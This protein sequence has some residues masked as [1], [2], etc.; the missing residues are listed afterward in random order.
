MKFVCFLLIICCAKGLRA[1]ISNK[2]FPPSFKFGAST[3][4]YQIEGG[5]DADGKGPSVWDTFV[6]KGGVT[7]DNSTG[8]VACDSYHKWEE[9]VQILKELGAQI[10]R[11][12][13]SWPR[14]LPDGTTKNIN[15]KGVEYYLNLI[16]ALKANNIEPIITLYHWD[17]PQSLEE[18]GGW[19]NPVTADYFGEYTRLCFQLFGSY[20]KYWITLN[21]PFIQCL[22]GY[23]VGLLAPGVVNLGEG[24]YK[25]AH[26]QLLA[27]AQ[28]YHIY[29]DEFRDSQNGKVGVNIPYSWM[30]PK[31]PNNSL[32]VEATERYFQFQC[33]LFANPVLIGNWPQLVIDRV[34]NLS[35]QEG[36][37]TSRLPEL[38]KEEIEFI[39]GTSDYIAL[40]SYSAS[41]VSYANDSTPLIPSYLTDYNVETSMN[42]SWPTSTAEWLVSYPEGL[43]LALN[44]INDR[45]HPSEIIITENGWSDDGQLNDIGRQE[46]MEGYLNSIL[47]AITEDGVNVTGYSTW[48]LLD[49]FEWAYG[50]TQS[51]GIIKVDFKDPNRTR[52]WKDSATWYKNVIENRF[53]TK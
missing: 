24:I 10:Y 44:Q 19:L 1:N 17:L 23:T 26:V 36:L 35:A 3:A 11:F 45:Y 2:V 51:Y 30:G 7:V 50:Y 41:L 15:Q 39:N 28:A 12:S 40:N 46:Y 21:E 47:E 49:N 48:S 5:W 14:I 53:I 43:R 4:A 8:D 34:G 31:D 25:C 27:H 33:G 52:T 32:D 16:K 6:H 29:D 37:A 20:I 9:D 18:N 38:T 22:H 42:D 13:I